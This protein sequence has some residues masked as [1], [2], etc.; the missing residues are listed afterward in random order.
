M[1]SSQ[2]QKTKSIT[3]RE[4]FIASLPLSAVGMM[5]GGQLFVAVHVDQKA[6]CK[7]N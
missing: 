1:I 6:C 2:Q 7:L 5:A 3:S 4:I